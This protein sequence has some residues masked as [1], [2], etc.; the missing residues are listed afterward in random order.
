MLVAVPY[1]VIIFL[2]Y[3]FGH[4]LDSMHGKCVIAYVSS[5]AIFHI[6]LAIVQL[7]D[8]KLRKFPFVCKTAGYLL[9]TSIFICFFWLH[10][11]CYDVWKG[12]R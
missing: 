3:S 2:F 7:D 12:F 9:Y 6:S 5:V 10:A 11:M 1:L 4:E 8:D